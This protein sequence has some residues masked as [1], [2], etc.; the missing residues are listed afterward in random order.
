[1]F[2]YATIADAARRHRCGW[3]QG[4]PDAALIGVAEV[5]EPGG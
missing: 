3:S 2:L 1:V 4:S 5:A